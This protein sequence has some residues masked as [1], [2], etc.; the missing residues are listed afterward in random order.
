MPRSQ[1]VAPSATIRRRTSGSTKVC[2]AAVMK[3]SH[4]RSL[5]MEWAT[6]AILRAVC[7]AVFATHSLQAFLNKKQGISA[8]HA[9]LVQRLSP[10]RHFN[11]SLQFHLGNGAIGLGAR[12]KSFG[13]RSRRSSPS[14]T[15]IGFLRTFSN[16]LGKLVSWFS[17]ATLAC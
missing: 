3:L 11:D 8:F 9:N 12:S 15:F 4:D 17:R 14:G 6:T 16:F 10:Q 13:T 2:R 1:F 5:A 7:R